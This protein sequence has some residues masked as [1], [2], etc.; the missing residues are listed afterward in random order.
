MAA[1][2]DFLPLWVTLPLL[3]ISC[4]MGLIVGAALFRASL[5]LAEV[6]WHGSLRM[7][8]ALTLAFAR[9][10]LLAFQWC[11]MAS[12]GTAQGLWT[13]ICMSWARTVGRLQA[14]LVARMQA[15]RQRAR[16]WD[17]WQGEFRDEFATFDEFLYAFE[18]GGKRREEYE[19]PKWDSSRRG[20][21]RQGGGDERKR[22]PPDP[23]EAAFAAACRLFGLP[24][25][26]FTRDQLNAR[27]RALM[28]ATHPDK[29]GSNQ[30]AAAINAAR[31][32]IKRTK[33][34]S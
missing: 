32:L 8:N 28:S 3:L 20:N 11:A 27:Y 4:A 1:V 31:D 14:A 2:L 13:L 15:L 6:A 33:G 9:A 17:T 25:S 16:L 29:G 24:E 34:W 7:V 19:E 10:G 26:G 30:R 5:M 18:H 21:E 12:L 22:A 23:R